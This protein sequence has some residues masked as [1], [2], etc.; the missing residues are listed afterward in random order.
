MV[1]KEVEL[2]LIVSKVW[3]P[4]KWFMKISREVKIWGSGNKELE[5]SPFLDREVGNIKDGHRV[6]QYDDKLKKHH[7]CHL[8]AKLFA[9]TEP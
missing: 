7:V 9:Q 6:T 2:W 3:V 4:T 8:F 5:R 1:I